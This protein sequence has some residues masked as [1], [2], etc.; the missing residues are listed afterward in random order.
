M[1]VEEALEQQRILTRFVEG[2][3]VVLKTIV[4]E[5]DLDGWPGSLQRRVQVAL[6]GKMWLSEAGLALSRVTP[7]AL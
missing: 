7:P 5:D 2:S 3:D 4:L 1:G 6:A